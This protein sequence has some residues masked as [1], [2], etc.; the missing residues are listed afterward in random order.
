MESFVTGGEDGQV[1]LFTHG[2]QDLN[3]L[4]TRSS[5]GCSI[6]SIKFSPNGQRVAVASE[7]AGYSH[8]H[9]KDVPTDKGTFAASSLQ[10]SSMCATRARCKSSKA[11]L[12]AYEPSPGR[13][14]GSLSYVSRTFIECYQIGTD[15]RSCHESV[16]IRLRRDDQSLG[17]FEPL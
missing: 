8:E 10:K 12:R 5:L 9:M 4:V 16:H 14:T 6:R 1:A 2:S 15:C 7:Y 13:P 11:T 3:K 17:R